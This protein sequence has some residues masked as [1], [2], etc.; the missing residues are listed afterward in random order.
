MSDHVRGDLEARLEEPLAV[1]AATRVD[2]H[3]TQC[4]AC[5]RYAADLDEGER[6]LSLR[7][8]RIELPP[9][10]V[11]IVRRQGFGGWALAAGIAAVAVAVFAWSAGQEGP[12]AP[13]L[14]E[15]AAAPTTA[16][17]AAPSA[18]AIVLPRDAVVAITRGTEAHVIVV[19][20]RPVANGTIR[21]E[22]QVLSG[23][24]IAVAA[25]VDRILVLDPGP[26]RRLRQFSAST[27]RL[28]SGSDVGARTGTRAAILAVSADAT[29]A[30]IARLSSGSWS[31]ETVDLA[32]G[33]SL[34]SAQLQGCERP[35]AAIAKDGQSLV[36]GCVGSS[37]LTS[38]V[39]GTQPST[40]SVPDPLVAVV[41]AGESVYAFT[42]SGG[43]WRVGGDALSPVVQLALE[44]LQPTAGA[45]SIAGDRVALG[46]HPSNASLETVTRV[47]L[48]DARQGLDLGLQNLFFNTGGGLVS[49]PSV[50]GFVLDPHGNFSPNGQLFGVRSDGTLF[51]DFVRVAGPPGEHVAAVIG[52][53][54]SAG[55][56]TADAAIKVADRALEGGG[57]KERVEAVAVSTADVVRAFPALETA[58]SSTTKSSTLWAVAEDGLVAYRGAKYVWVILVVDPI[59]GQVVGGLG[60][61]S[62]PRPP[63]FDAFPR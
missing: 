36:A 23:S 6:L 55:A 39:A 45:I 22:I 13:E 49:T 44:G 46:L 12:V 28:E 33:A 42:N 48:F 38:V 4:P 59:S 9:R 29:R 16:V 5:R 18:P 58:I 3:L 21:L 7:E 62:G 60:G 40:V 20:Q 47:A 24:S 57:R 14:T 17:L 37:T 31:I 8:S 10:R 35:S 19:D 56:T 1:S 15:P 34:L 2:A 54:D 11:A 61:V 53:V 43:I 26:S 51:G 50:G 32:S 27:G 30:A 25:P 63:A 41:Q 52:L